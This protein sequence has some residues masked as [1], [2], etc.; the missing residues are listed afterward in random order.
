MCRMRGQGISVGDSI[1]AGSL[2]YQSVRLV[3]T[4]LT[5]HRCASLDFSKK[6]LAMQF[7]V[8]AGSLYGLYDNRALTT[9]CFLGRQNFRQP[10]LYGN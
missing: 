9:V 8:R 3:C 2:L 4:P 10:A 7:Y 5:P 6:T 1:L